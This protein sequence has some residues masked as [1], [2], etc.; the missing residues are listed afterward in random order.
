MSFLLCLTF[1][2]IDYKRSKK[3]KLQHQE[4]I[5]ILIPCYNDGDSIADTI[6]S[7]YASWPQDLLQVIVINDASTDTSFAQLKTL[8]ER[9]GFTLRDNPVNQGKTRSLN[10]AVDLAEH[11]YLLIL[12]ADTLLQKKHLVDMLARMQRNSRVAAVSC[13]YQAKNTGFLPAMTEIE[14][15]MLTIVQGSYNL[16]GAIALRGGCLLVKKQ[17]FLQVNKF[18]P[19]MLTEDMDLAF[20]L[21]KAGYKV[22]QSLISIKSIVPDHFR[23]RWKQKIRRNSGGAHCFIKYPTVWIKNPLHITLIVSFCLLLFAFVLNTVLSWDLLKHLLDQPNLRKSFRAIFDIKRRM[24][25]F[26]IKTSYAF[27]SLPYV[28]PL[29]HSWRTLWRI[30]WIFPYSLLYLPLYAIAGAV[31]MIRGIW[32]YRSLEKIGKKG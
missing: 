23:R 1:F 10:Q 9:Y 8:Q 25:F 32:Q 13:P 30:L 18:S 15:R 24:E 14:Y 22:E 31:G 27:L 4:P 5:S 11:E 20:K 26:L 19:Q 12:D 2:L 6:K 29:I 7:V 16:F 28:L 21:N 3:L 17:P